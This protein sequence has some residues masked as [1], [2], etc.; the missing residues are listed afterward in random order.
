VSCS[1]NR[2][3]PGPDG[4]SVAK[5]FAYSLALRGFR[6]TLH[7]YDGFVIA[8]PL[9]IKYLGWKKPEGAPKKKPEGL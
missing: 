9:W 3:T 1:H 8:I 5:V 7:R 6:S 2:K 4:I